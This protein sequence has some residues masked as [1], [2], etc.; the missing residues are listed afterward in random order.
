MGL[1]I[2]PISPADKTRRRLRRP[3]QSP[4]GSNKSVPPQG[5]G[6]GEAFEVD[7]SPAGAEKSEE[8]QREQGQTPEE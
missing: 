1:E 3:P 8:F 4:S 5:S 2:P 7:I 6:I